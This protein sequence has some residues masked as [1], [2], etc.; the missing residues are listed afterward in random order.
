MDQLGETLGEK[1]YWD[2]HKRGAE[3]YVA[4]CPHHKMSVHYTAWGAC[5]QCL[6]PPEKL[7]GDARLFGLTAYAGRCLYH[8]PSAM[9][10]LTGKCVACFTSTGNVRMAT[11]VKGSCE[12]RRVA[13]REHA[14][15]YEDRCA[16]HGRTAHWTK[17]GQC[18]LCYTSRGNAR[19]FAKA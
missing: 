13:W 1:A 5:A 16:F 15:T 8:G 14:A 18:H 12:A 19:N 17:S 7:R 4:R 9:W 6:S 3:F 10:C 11:P 2:S